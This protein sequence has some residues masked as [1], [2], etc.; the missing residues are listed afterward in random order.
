[1]MGLHL[2]HRIHVQHIGNPGFTLQHSE[3]SENTRKLYGTDEEGSK[4]TVSVVGVLGR[5]HNSNVV[6]V[7]FAKRNSS[8]D[9]F[10]INN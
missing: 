10:S 2:R 3:K 5:F 8:K 7:L 9:L 4:E 6:S 1:M